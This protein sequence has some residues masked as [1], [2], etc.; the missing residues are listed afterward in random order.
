MVQIE[1]EESTIIYTPQ[2]QMIKYS[3][4]I[5]SNAALNPDKIESIRKDVM[6]MFDCIEELQKLGI[7][8]RDITPS[9]FMKRSDTEEIILMCYF[10]A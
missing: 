1:E 5:I 3:E 9:H 10:F 6:Q 8:H 7:I 4:M 2:C